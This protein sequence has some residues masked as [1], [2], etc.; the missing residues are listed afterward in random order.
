M[1]WGAR[2]RD[3]QGLDM[4]PSVT[5]VRFAKCVLRYVVMFN[6]SPATRIKLGATAGFGVQQG[7]GPGTVGAP[8]G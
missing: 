3:Q 7:L 4:V 1:P 2:V 6:R 8:Q 5:K